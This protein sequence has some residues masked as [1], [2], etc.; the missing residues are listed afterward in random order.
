MTYKDLSALPPLVGNTILLSLQIKMH[1][2]ATR[3]ADYLEEA[4][5]TM[6]YGHRPYF[7]SVAATSISSADLR[8]SLQPERGIDLVFSLTSASI[9][10]LTVSVPDSL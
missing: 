1:L 2:E 8:D 3:M 5:G 6:N 4:T 7:S 10:R 9:N